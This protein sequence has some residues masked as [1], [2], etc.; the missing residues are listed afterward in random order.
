MSILEKFLKEMV[1][2]VFNFDRDMKSL[3]NIHLYQQDF[4]AKPYSSE[5]TPNNLLKRYGFLKNKLPIIGVGSSRAVFKLSSKKVLKV[6]ING[7]GIAQNKV[8]YNSFAKHPNSKWIPKIYKVAE[9]YSWLVCELVRPLSFSNVDVALFEKT[10]GFASW[11]AIPI[12]KAVIKSLKQKL[13]IKIELLPDWP[14]NQEAA[15]NIIEFST[16]LLANN[17]RPEDLKIENLGVKPI[18]QLVMLDTGYNDEVKN[19]WY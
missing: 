13:P 16:F 10:F 14:E 7:G 9:D 12:I 1:E 6:A 4:L 19:N 15:D 11:D 8:E 18:G 5:I 17:I 2:S 3:E